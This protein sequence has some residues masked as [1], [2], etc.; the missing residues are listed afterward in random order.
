MPVVDKPGWKAGREIEV[1][2]VWT[3]AAGMSDA[4]RLVWD[5]GSR[6]T[7]CPWDELVIWWV[8]A[9]IFIA[10]S[11]VTMFVF[12]SPATV[13]LL[14]I[15]SVG[16]LSIW[17]AHFYNSL[18]VDRIAISRI[19]VDISATT[20]I[21]FGTRYQSFSCLVSWKDIVSIEVCDVGMEGTSS[22]TGVSV[23]QRNA[24]RLGKSVVINMP[25]EAKAEQ[26]VARAMAIY[27]TDE[28]AS[29]RQ[30]LR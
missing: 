8:V 9:L 15:A 27:P 5:T 3:K 1:D 20:K 21:R 6:H 24:G 7:G 23:N 18:V 11:M 4:S 12:E 2:N 30:R 26:F 13:F 14:G 10:G 19:G 25:S 16:L 17:I 28:I 29:N 22:L